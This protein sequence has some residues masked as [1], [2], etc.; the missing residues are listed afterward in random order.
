MKR[1]FITNFIVFFL[2]TPAH[3][4]NLLQPSGGRTSSLG[5]C[6]VAS[7]DFWSCINSPAGF[8]SQKEISIGF[9][10]QNKFLLKELGYKNA[11]IL[12]PLN[13]G[14]IGVSFSQFGYNLYNENIIGLGFAR[15]FGDKLRI[16]L[17]LD[18]LFFKFPENYENKSAPTFELGIQYQINESLCLGAYFFNPINVKLRTIN[19]DKIPIII[20]LGFSY[21]ITKDF[22]ITSEIEENFEH[23]FSYRIGLEYDIYKNIFLRS[24]FQLNPEIF[25]FGVGYNY[26]WCII[27]VCAQMNQELGTSINCSFI[28]NIKNRRIAI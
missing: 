10:Y 19:R 9:S 22:L 25:T 2:F 26:K 21:H 24:G 11:G 8:A 15:N 12:L 13:I 16:G 6:S 23:N 18:Y 4:W 20:R 17:K 14:V 7:N 28:F 3:S 1:F 27:D 5:N